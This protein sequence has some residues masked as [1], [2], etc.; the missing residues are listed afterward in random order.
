MLQFVI[1]KPLTAIAAII[2]HQY[3]VYCEGEWDFNCGYIY[4]STI[5]NTSV[6]IALYYL[7]LFYLATEERLAPFKPVNKF[8]SVKAILVMSFWQASLFQLLHLMK[9]VPAQY[10]GFILNLIICFE[11]VIIALAHL[12]AFPWTDYI[13]ERHDQASRFKK[14]QTFCQ[15]I[16]RILFASRDVIDDVQNTFVNDYKDQ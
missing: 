9:L 11:M 1:I 15:N 5:N 14:S 7:V 10:G 3:D 13:D 12:Y 8:L 16:F 4:I 6:S 2:L